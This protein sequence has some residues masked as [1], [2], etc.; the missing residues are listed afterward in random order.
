MAATMAYASSPSAIAWVGM[1]IIS[2][3]FTAPGLVGF[4]AANDNPVLSFLD[5]PGKKIEVCLLAWAL[6]SVTLGIGHSTD[7]HE[8]LIL[9]SFKV[10]EKPREVFGTHFSSISKVVMYRALKSVKS[11]T[12]LETARGF[13]GDQAEHLDLFIEV[14]DR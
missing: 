5:Y 10:L 13:V 9:K 4:G 8:V 3:L 7:E 2:W 14:L 1:I 11:H 6:G 12:S